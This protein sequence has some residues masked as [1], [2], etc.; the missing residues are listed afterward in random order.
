MMAQ[1]LLCHCE[2]SE[3]IQLFGMPR[4]S[5]SPRRFAPRDDGGRMNP[6]PICH[7][8][9]SEAIQCLGMP[10]NSGSPH[11]FAPRDDGYCRGSMGSSSRFFASFA[12]KKS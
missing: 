1:H 6:D 7:C 12:D 5:G 8:E 2:R 9:H 10:R 4:N 3:A 11:R